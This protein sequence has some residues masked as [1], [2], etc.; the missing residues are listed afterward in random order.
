MNLKWFFT[1]AEQPGRFAFL[2]GI[3]VFMGMLVSASLWM[4][5]GPVAAG[6]AAALVAGSGGAFV[7][8]WMERER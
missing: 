4:D 1:P 6:V 3:V 8:W 5:R 2:T 7:K